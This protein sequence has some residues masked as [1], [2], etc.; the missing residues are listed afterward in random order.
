[1]GDSIDLGHGV[2]MRWAGWHPDRELNPQ[3]DGIPDDPHSLVIVGHVHEDG[4]VCEGGVPLDTPV[5]RALAARDKRLAQRSVWQVESLDPLT[6][7]P[8]ILKTECGLH[9]FIRGGRWVPA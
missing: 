2:Y 1:M 6:I 4:S 8:S 7:S 3:Y 9:G 5:H